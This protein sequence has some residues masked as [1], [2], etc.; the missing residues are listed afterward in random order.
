MA[1]MALRWAFER[2]PTKLNKRLTAF[3]NKKHI[4][5]IDERIAVDDEDDLDEQ[6]Y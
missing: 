3:G 6:K 1:F 5:M 4:N 2:R